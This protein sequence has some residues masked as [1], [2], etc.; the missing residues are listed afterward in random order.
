MATS[1]PADVK[2]A[3]NGWL[4][5][6]RALTEPQFAESAKKFVRPGEITWIVVGDLKRIEKGVREL[7][8][9]EIIK[10]NANGEPVN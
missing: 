9:G 7:G 2:A 1:K 3:V 6:I 8:Y 10:L 5:N 4:R